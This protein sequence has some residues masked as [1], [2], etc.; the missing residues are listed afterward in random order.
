MRGK[1]LNLVRFEDFTAVTMKNT[2]FCD[3]TP[4][5]YCKNLSSS[6][7]LVL[8][9][10][11]Q[12]NIP[13]DSIL[14]AKIYLATLTFPKLFFIQKWASKESEISSGKCKTR[15]STNCSYERCHLLGYGAIQSV[16]EPT[17]GGTYH[18]V[19]SG[20]LGRHLLHARFLLGRFTSLKIETIDSSETWVS[21]KD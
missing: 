21:D 15:G 10:A 14:Q 16:C 7:T 1:K 18:C 20:W 9:T 19:V 13:E 11:T 12:P 17:F 4:S 3:V 8:T 5:G 2:V 6:K